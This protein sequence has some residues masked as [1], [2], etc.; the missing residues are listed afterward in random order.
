MVEEKKQ[1]QKSKSEREDWEKPMPRTFVE[2]FSKKEEP[3][4]PG[5]KVSKLEERKEK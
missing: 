4:A 1:D 3:L 5:T 2:K